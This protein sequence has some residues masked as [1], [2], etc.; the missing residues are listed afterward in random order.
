[1][2]DAE[3]LFARLIAPLTAT[4]LMELHGFLDS[5]GVDRLEDLLAYTLRG[6]YP[7]EATEYFGEGSPI[8]AVQP[9]KRSSGLLRAIFD[10]T[11]TDEQWEEHAWREEMAARIRK[12]SDT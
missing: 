9:A 2:A 6:K 11:E 4:E 7:N 3:A 5:G 1:M 12:I 8:L 10:A